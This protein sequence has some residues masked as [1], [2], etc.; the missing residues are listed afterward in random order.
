MLCSCNGLDG[1]FVEVNTM[2][3]VGVWSKLVLLGRRSVELV[4]DS[5]TV[6]P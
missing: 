3:L 5:R 6:E 2:P 4:Q 1:V